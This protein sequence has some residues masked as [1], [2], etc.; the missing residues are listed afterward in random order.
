MLYR[1]QSTGYVYEISLERQG[2]IYQATVDGQ[3]YPVDVL[4]SQPGQLSLRFEGRPLTIYWAVE[5]NQKWLSLDGCVYCLEKPTSRAVRPSSEPGG[6]QAVR[7][8]MPAQVRDVQVA[9]G[10]VVEKGQTLLLLEAMKMEIRIKA[11][12]AGRL[13]RLLVKPGQAV[14][15]EQVLAELQAKEDGEKGG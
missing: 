1:F 12:T 15:K 10:D 6:G 7:A 14:E 4:D 11:P 3:T 9:E 5:G 2:E 13:A 8:P